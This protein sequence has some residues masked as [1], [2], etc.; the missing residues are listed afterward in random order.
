MLVILLFSKFIMNFSHFSNKN[1]GTLRDL[2]TG[3]WPV[4]TVISRSSEHGGAARCLSDTS[5]RCALTIYC[6]STSFLHQSKQYMTMAHIGLLLGKSSHQAIF[7][8]TN[9]CWQLSW[10]YSEDCSDCN[11]SHSRGR[12]IRK[13]HHSEANENSTCRW[14]QWRVSIFYIFYVPYVIVGPIISV[15]C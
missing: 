14:I 3:F 4:C 7:Y 8:G 12:R 2:Q 5:V 11:V 13:E 9:F 6:R 10:Y 15:M 1:I